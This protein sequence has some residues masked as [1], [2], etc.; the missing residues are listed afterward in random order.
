M[1][2]R[3]ISNIRNLRWD[4]AL[5][6]LIVVAVGLLMA[7]QVDRWWESRDE[8]EI[9]RQYIVRLI[10]DLERDVEN[11]D[12]A[13]GLADLRLSFAGMLM[14]VA[15]EPKLAMQSPVKF[16]L[17]VNQSAFTHT[18]ALTSNTFEELR[19]TGKLGLLRSSE[20]RNSLFD[21]Y[22]FDNS[23]RQYQ[24]LQYMQEFRHFEFAAGILTNRQLTRMHDEWFVVDATELAALQ[25]EAV[26]ETEVLEAANRLQAD[27]DFVNWLPISYEM[28]REAIDGNQ[29]RLDR[30]TELLGILTTLQNDV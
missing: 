12:Y 11:L 5:L 26:D 20:L 27:T 18:P 4:N 7:F 17:A 23:E 13:I 2:L 25:D 10:T 8:L 24:T 29:E 16:M 30:A 28:Q 1:L 3:I 9:E 22:R 19:S 14:D 6:E 21:Y 15:E